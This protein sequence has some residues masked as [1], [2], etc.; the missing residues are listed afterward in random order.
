MET[1]NLDR[2][3]QNCNYFFS[4]TEDVASGMGVCLRGE[5]FEPFVDEIMESSSFASCSDL[6]VEQRYDGEQAAC[7]EYDEVEIIECSDEEMDG[8]LLNEMVKRQNVEGIV[9]ALYS[10]NHEEIDR[11]IT[12]LSAY[13]YAGN[14]QALKGVID[15]YAALPPAIHLEDVHRRL[16]IVKVLANPKFAEEAIPLCINELART[17]SNQTT[18]QLYTEIMKFLKRCPPDLI[19][20][21]LLLLLETREYSY[22]ISK[23][24]V[25]LSKVNNRS[26]GGSHSHT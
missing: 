11:A 1:V 6:Y 3:C 2:I 4:D 5:A 14:E 24:Y 12:S 15:Y 9:A 26:V 25:K 17:P 23:G 20:E 8:Y 19:R 18:R 22:R 10:T 16:N 7:L 21:P 13:I